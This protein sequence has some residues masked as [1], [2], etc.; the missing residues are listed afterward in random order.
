VAEF[1]TFMDAYVQYNYLMLLSVL[2]GAQRAQVS[3]ATFR[4][5]YRVGRFPVLRLSRRVIRVDVADLERFLAA[6]KVQH[7]DAV[8]G[9]AR[10]AR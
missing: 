10:A 4:R 6:H 9:G 5:W 1:T 8:A 3:V 2:E 7:I